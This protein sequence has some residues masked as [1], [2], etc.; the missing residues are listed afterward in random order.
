MDT[1]RQPSTPPGNDQAM[2]YAEF[3]RE[4]FAK[5]QRRSAPEPPRPAPARPYDPANPEAIST[6]EFYRQLF[7]EARHTPLALEGTAAF[8]GERGALYASFAFDEEEP[9]NCLACGL[10]THWPVLCASCLERLE[11]VDPELACPFY[12]ADARCAADCENGLLTSGCGG[13]LGACHHP[14]LLS[15]RPLAKRS[16][17]RHEG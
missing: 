3:Y 5:K 14:D 13:L 16:E 10:E 4:L 2:T 8:S 9:G 17:G 11:E 7:A 15:G 12:V 6:E 1:Y